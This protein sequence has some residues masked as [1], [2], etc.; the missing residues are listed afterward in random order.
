MNSVEPI[1]DIQIVYDI[2][3]YLKEKNVRDYVMFLFG[4]NTGLRISDILK[5][6]TR[7][8]RDSKGN[9]KSHIELTEKKTGKDKKLKINSDI[10]PILK[11]YLKNKK[12]YEYIIKSPKGTNNPLSR[13]QA[14]RILSEVGELFGVDDMGCHT[15]RKTLGYHYYKKTNDIAGLM[16]LYNHSSP[17]ITLGYIGMD[18]DK[19]DL[20]IEKLNFVR[21]R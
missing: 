6:R 2:Q 12:E 17:V 9:I 14:Y 15:L 19:K 18:Q 8:I 21:K 11:D 10:K 20:M 13:Q 3:D 5:L 16:K 4:V 7:D 1:R